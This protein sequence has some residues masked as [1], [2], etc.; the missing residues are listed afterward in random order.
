MPNIL[1]SAWNKH[2]VIKDSDIVSLNKDR[3]LRRLLDEVTSAMYGSLSKIAKWD[4]TNL[5]KEPSWRSNRVLLNIYNK[6]HLQRDTIKIMR[7][8]INN[9]DSI[10]KT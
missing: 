7:H 3:A 5:E 1:T 9:S 6:L 8:V 10:I 2:D 4:L